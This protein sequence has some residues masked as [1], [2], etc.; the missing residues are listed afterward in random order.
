MKEKLASLDDLISLV[1]PLLLN[2]GLGIPQDL[3][4]TPIPSKSFVLFCFK[5]LFLF[6]VILKN[7]FCLAFLVILSKMVS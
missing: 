2:L 4:N 1:F 5:F 7:I 6:F 3:E